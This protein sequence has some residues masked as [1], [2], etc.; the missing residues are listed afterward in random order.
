MSKETFENLK[1]EIEAIDKAEIIEPQIPIAIA[2]QESEDLYQWAQDDHA[3]LEKAGL[4]MLLLDQLPERTAALRYIQSIWQKEYKTMEKAQE[5]WGKISPAA[6][7]LRDTLVHEF[8]HAFHKFPA[9][10]AQIKHID[11]GAGNADMIQ[12]LSDLLVLG[13]ANPDLLAEINFDNTLLSKSE[14]FSKTLP[15]LLAKANGLRNSDNKTKVL[16]DKAYTHMKHAVDEI[17]RNGVYKFWR[18]PER[19]KGYVSKYNTRNR[20]SKN[21]NQTETK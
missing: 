20:G 11:E 4:E 12:D 18:T 21:E 14:E 13:K 10:L 3:D 19:K 5:E 2:L 16:R 6:F 9:L 8:R 1:K 17:R 7:D 15:D